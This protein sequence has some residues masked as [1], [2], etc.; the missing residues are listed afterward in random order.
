MN[1]DRLPFSKQKPSLAPYPA[2]DFIDNRLDSEFHPA[3]GRSDVTFCNELDQYVSRNGES[4]LAKRQPQPVAGTEEMSRQRRKFESAVGEYERKCKH[5]TG[6]DLRKAHDWSEVLEAV[7]TARGKYEGTHEKG[8]C[9]TMRHGFRSFSS[10]QSAVQSWLRVLP[11]SSMEA[12]VLCGGIQ[13]IF[14]V[15]F[16]ILSSLSFSIVWM[17][18]H[19]GKAAGRLGKMRQDSYG[20]LDQIPISISKAEALMAVYEDS[21]QLETHVSKLYVAILDLLEHILEWYAKNPAKKVLYAVFQGDEYGS[22]LDEKYRQLQKLEQHVEGQ[23]AVDQHKRLG[24]VDQNIKFRRPPRPL[25]R[26][27]SP[28]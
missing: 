9:T 24:A 18:T 27:M 12:S 3:F 28:S 16:P 11:Q 15:S 7:N 6:I 26:P 1:Q 25:L 23:A 19:C 14:S 2:V 22:K 10:A 4:A 20:A 5:Q 17:R 8:F 13:I 21:R